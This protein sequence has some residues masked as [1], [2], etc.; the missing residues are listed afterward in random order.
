VTKVYL[1]IKSISEIVNG[2][3]FLARLFIENKDQEWVQAAK[4]TFQVLK[5]LNTPEKRRETA[6]KING[7]F[8]DVAG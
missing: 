2:L 8:R 7:F 3:V 6:K 5:T 1:I 4:G